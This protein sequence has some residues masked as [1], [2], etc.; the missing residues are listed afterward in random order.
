MVT[1]TLEL[2]HEASATA[3]QQAVVDRAWVL[4]RLRENVERSMQ[5]VEVKSRTGRPTAHFFG[6]MRI[7]Q[8]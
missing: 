2:R 8:T 3:V 4:M 6:K 7:A 5:I 1:V